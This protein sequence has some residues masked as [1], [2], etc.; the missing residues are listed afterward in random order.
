MTVARLHLASEQFAARPENV[1]FRNPVGPVP[2]IQERLRILHAWT[3]SRLQAAS[4]ALS[5][6]PSAFSQPA[7][8]I[9]NNFIAWS[10]PV[11]S[12]LQSLASELVPLQM[13]WRDL[14]EA[15]VLL[16]GDQVTGL[17]DP[18]AA[19]IDHFTTDLSRLLGGMFGDDH[20]GW[21]AALACYETLHPLTTV[22]RKMLLALDHSST[23]LSGMTWIERWQAGEIPHDDIPRIAPRLER[24]AMRGASLAGAKG[25]HL[26]LRTTR[27]ET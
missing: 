8:Q 18:D 14:H 25:F 3:P 11:Q 17:I 21:Q 19:R 24:W 9:L 12:E 4:N 2:A 7:I 26:N 20:A 27:F 1:A 10:G 5:R 6:A 16:T 23:L 13:C 15:H 22:D